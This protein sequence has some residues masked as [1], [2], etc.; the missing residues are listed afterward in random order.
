[1]NVDFK[2]LYFGVPT[3]ASS[4]LAAIG[5]AVQCTV[6]YFVLDT[7]VLYYCAV[8]LIHSYCNEYSKQFLQK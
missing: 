6:L 8:M 7:T 2:C 5:N 1:M 3:W 4:V